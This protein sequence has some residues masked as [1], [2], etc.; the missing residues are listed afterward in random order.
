MTKYT[1]W[2][3][4]KVVATATSMR[5]ATLTELVADELRLFFFPSIQ[6]T[7]PVLFEH[8]AGKALGAFLEGSGLET[9]SEHVEPLRYVHGRTETMRGTNK[10]SSVLLAEIRHPE[11]VDEALWLSN[12][13][14]I[15]T[16]FLALSD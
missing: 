5:R 9:D 11:P 10:I 7:P 6:L 3:G 4:G 15:Y 12:L 8:L 14:T 16:K 2:K 13:P 1:I